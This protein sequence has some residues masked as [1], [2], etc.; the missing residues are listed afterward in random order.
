[1]YMKVGAH[2]YEVLV[3]KTV[4]D[5]DPEYVQKVLGQKRFDPLG[6]RVNPKSRG[7]RAQVS[8]EKQVVAAYTKGMR[9][10]SPKAEYDKARAAWVAYKKGLNSQLQ[11]LV[12]ALQ[13]G[14]LTEKGFLSKAQALLRAGYER[15]YRLGTDA[16]GMGA[17]KLPA[18]DLA[19]LARARRAEYRFLDKFARDIVQGKGTMSYRDR[20]S[21]YV[22]SMDGMF[23]A[24]RIDAYP[25]EGTLIYWEL[26]AAESCGDCID[27]AINSPY[28]PD[29]LPTTPRAGGTACLS[30]CQCS[31]RVRYVPPTKTDLEIRRVSPD[32]AR[33]LGLA[34]VTAATI[35]PLL[36]PKDMAPSKG[37]DPSSAS[38]LDMD[39]DGEESVAVLDWNKLDE[40]LSA[41]AK[42][43]ML[44]RYEPSEHRL[45]EELHENDR[46][47]EASKSLPTWLD[48]FSR[49]VYVWHAIGTRVLEHVG[50]EMPEEVKM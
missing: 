23:D 41:L 11:D 3:E 30:H 42:L 25:A 10:L 38:G 37:G 36:K 27:L 31:L 33:K 47:A 43:R 50:Q 19:W 17:F 24:G 8:A 5:L 1:M 7:S 26:S 45:H 40:M 22:D 13:G 35:A 4:D 21:M 32:A 20:A 28:T 18:E 2:W 39:Y 12:V 14:T 16:G 44:E 34:F 29:E 48:P 9:P 6:S 15:A 49:E 46:F